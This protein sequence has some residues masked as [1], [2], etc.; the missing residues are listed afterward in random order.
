MSTTGPIRSAL[1][2]AT[3][4]ADAPGARRPRL[5]TYG[6]Q[7]PCELFIEIRLVRN[8]RG[9]FTLSPFTSAAATDDLFVTVIVQVIRPPMC[10]AAG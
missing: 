3:T 4:V 1:V 5:H 2:T 9:S 7:V 10:T 6:R 8:E